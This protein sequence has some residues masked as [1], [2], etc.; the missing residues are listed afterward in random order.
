MHKLQ[1]LEK[2]KSF[3]KNRGNPAIQNNKAPVVNYY[4]GFIGICAQD[5]IRTS[6]SFRTLPPEGSASTNFA[7]WA[8]S[9]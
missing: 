4:R 9:G 2:Y 8:R 3:G 6:T 1:F 5:W 7:T